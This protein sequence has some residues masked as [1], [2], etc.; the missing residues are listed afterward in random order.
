MPKATVFSKDIKEAICKRRTFFE[1]EKNA[2]KSMITIDKP[3]E[4]TVATLGVSLVWIECGITSYR[5]A[6]IPQSKQI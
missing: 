2:G 1:M 5:C 4:R 6:Y 3:R